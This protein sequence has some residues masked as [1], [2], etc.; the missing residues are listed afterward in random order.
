MENNIENNEVQHKTA[1]K[2]DNKGGQILYGGFWARLAAYFIDYIVV[3]MA[4]MFLYMPF[5]FLLEYGGDFVEGV[6]GI[7]LSLLSI[8]LGF[9]YYVYM[10]YKYQATL[11]KMAIG[12]KVLNDQGKKPTLSEV[13]M[14]EVLGKI[15]SSLTLGIGYLIAAF[16]NKK[17]ALHDMIGRT[18]VVCKDQQKGTNKVVVILVNVG[19]IGLFMA[20][21]LFIFIVLIA[22]FAASEGGF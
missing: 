2:Q 20:L 15:V 13:M 12:I 5:G 19:V 10:T 4:L 9:G 14:R 16:T 11:G 18:I 3:N 6:F 8:V 1:E 17:Q 21:F 7:L 22:A